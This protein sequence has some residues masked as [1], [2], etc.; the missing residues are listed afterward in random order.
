MFYNCINLMS[1]DLSG[2]NTNNVKNIEFM[3]A[4]CKKLFNLNISS[5]NLKNVNKKDKIFFG[6]DNLENIIINYDLYGQ[7]G[8]ELNI[9]NLTIIYPY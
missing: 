9:F 7:I 5:F 6:C 8:Q 3:F 1:V 2:F 4:N